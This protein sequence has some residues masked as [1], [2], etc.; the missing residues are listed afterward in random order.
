[1]TPT[2]AQE[3][4]REIGENLEL[5]FRAIDIIAQALLDVAKERDGEIDRLKKIQSDLSGATS[6]RLLHEAYD[7]VDKLRE[8]LQDIYFHCEGMACGDIAKKALYNSTEKK[9]SA[10]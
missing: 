5:G 8:A 10:K 9:E 1:M 4:A 6:S 7:R 2:Q 3:K